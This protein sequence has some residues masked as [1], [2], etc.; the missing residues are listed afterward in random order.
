MLSNGL[1][2]PPTMLQNAPLGA[3]DKRGWANPVHDPHG[4]LIDLHTFDQ[5]AND[6]APR[7]PVGLL[8]A[9]PNPAREFLQASDHEP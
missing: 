3:N 6:L 1:I 9:V 4:L 8:K 2:T 7:G 5:R